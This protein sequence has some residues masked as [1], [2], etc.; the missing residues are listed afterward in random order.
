MYRR[1]R[2]VD[3]TEIREALDKTQAHLLATANAAEA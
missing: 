2:I 3:E 1:Y